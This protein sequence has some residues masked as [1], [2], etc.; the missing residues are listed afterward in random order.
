M[1]APTVP[2]PDGVTQLQTFEAVTEVRKRD[3]WVVLLGNRQFCVTDN[4]LVTL[5]KRQK[6]VVGRDSRGVLVI[7]VTASALRESGL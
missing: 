2:W 3:N 1:E 7:H 5:L 4:V 6:V